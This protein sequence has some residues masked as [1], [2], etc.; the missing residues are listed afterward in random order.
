[1]PHIGVLIDTTSN[2]TSALLSGVNRYIATHHPWR[3]V[4]GDRSLDATH[5]AWLQGWRGDGMIAQIGTQAT[6]DAI[7]AIGVPAVAVTASR[8]DHPFPFVGV[9]DR[10]VGRMVAKHFFERGYKNFGLY[11]LANATLFEE[12]CRS[13]VDTVQ[14][15]GHECPVY[16]STQSPEKSRNWERQQGKLAAWVAELPKP[17]GVMCCTDPLGLSLL[18]ACHRARV[19]VPEEL[20]VVGAE[21][22]ETVCAMA[23]PPLSSVDMNGRA[24]GYEAAGL[25]SGMMEGQRPNS[26]ET[27]VAPLGVFVR[28]SSDVV[29]IDN[30]GV[31]AA[32]LYIRKHACEGVTVDDVARVT[33]MSRSTLERQM[34][35]AIKRTPKAEIQ[36]VKFDRVKELLG[37]TDLPLTAVA[38]RAGFEH[39][40]YMSEAFKREFGRTPGE[41]RRMMQR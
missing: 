26:R 23:T 18:D 12:K 37:D 15:A 14:A 22:D 39:P 20:A 2:L 30:K 10:A 28:Q 41:Y 24:I 25:L 16:R 27:L 4:I 32:L 31:R 29:A 8:L 21:N 13:F 9:D 17:A 34:A 6:I 35:S 33:Y 3:V 11:E 36:R 19:A 7:L 38:K 1:M 5:P 40:Q